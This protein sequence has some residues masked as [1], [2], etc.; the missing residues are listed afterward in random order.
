MHDLFSV[1]LWEYL[2]L[3]NEFRGIFELGRASVF[4]LLTMYTLLYHVRKI[5]RVTMF[6]N[7]CNVYPKCSNDF[8]RDHLGAIDRGSGWVGK[9]FCVVCSSLLVGTLRQSDL[10]RAC[11]IYCIVFMEISQFHWLLGTMSNLCMCMC[12]CTHDGSKYDL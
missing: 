2:K 3:R 4:F 12:M 11:N 9:E 10:F 5:C 1:Y 7:V 8:V 6:T